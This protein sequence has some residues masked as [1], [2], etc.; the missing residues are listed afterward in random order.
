[1][2]YLWLFSQEGRQWWAEECAHWGLCI[3]IST[4]LLFGSIRKKAKPYTMAVMGS[5]GCQHIYIN[6]ME[7]WGRLGD[8]PLLLR[9]VHP[10]NQGSNLA[11]SFCSYKEKRGDTW[12]TQVSLGTWSYRICRVP[13]K[14]ELTLLWEKIAKKKKVFSNT[15]VLLLFVLWEWR[16]VLGRGLGVQEQLGRLWKW[17]AA[18]S[19]KQGGF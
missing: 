16:D 6:M 7:L 17:E 18:S 5:L 12:Q 11:G 3:I 15:P 9:L 1:M 10:M 14:R 19:M 13:D 2:N 4:L 8:V